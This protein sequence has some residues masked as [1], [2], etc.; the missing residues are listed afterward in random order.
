M[1]DQDP[2]TLDHGEL[3]VLFTTTEQF[4]N[5]PARSKLIHALRNTDGVMPRRSGKRG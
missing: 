4:P 5:P 2:S 1:G 3:L